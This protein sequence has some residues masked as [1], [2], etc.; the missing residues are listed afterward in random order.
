MALPPVA[1]SVAD[2]TVREA[3]GAVLAFVVTLDRARS[4]AVAVDYATVPGTGGGVA[5]EGSDYTATS[6]TLTF[7]ANETLKTVEVP[8]LGRPA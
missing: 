6:G 3:A 5:T 1:I 4:E 8:V 2:A 7:A